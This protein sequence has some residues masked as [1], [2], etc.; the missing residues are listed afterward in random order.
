MI[1]LITCSML[2]VCQSSVVDCLNKVGKALCF[3]Q[4]SVVSDHKIN[5]LKQSPLSDPQNQVCHFSTPETLIK[6]SAFGII[7]WTMDKSR[8]PITSAITALVLAG[9]VKGKGGPPWAESCF[10]ATGSALAAQF[11][12]LFAVGGTE[13]R[14]VGGCQS[15]GKAAVQAGFCDQ[16]VHA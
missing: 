3:V 1:A 15:R 9:S 5:S 11:Q 10:W 4:Y 16:D 6:S 12:H 7:D 14:R 2:R 13:R 8:C